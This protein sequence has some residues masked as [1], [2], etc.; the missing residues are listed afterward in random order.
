MPPVPDRGRHINLSFDE[1]GLFEV[2]HRIVRPLELGAGKPV[3]ILQ[4]WDSR[5]V[6]MLFGR[7]CGSSVDGHAIALRLNGFEVRLIELHRTLIFPCPA[8]RGICEMIAQDSEARV[9]RLAV[10]LPLRN[11]RGLPEL[12]RR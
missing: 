12:I 2:R 3:A 1:F 4:R 10:V 6:A 11:L 8:T 5:V 9:C 7:L